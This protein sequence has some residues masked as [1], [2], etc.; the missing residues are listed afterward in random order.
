MFKQA[1]KN[2]IDTLGVKTL[3]GSRVKSVLDY[4]ID[5]TK[6]SAEAIKYLHTNTEDA[7]NII[8][9]LYLQPVYSTEFIEC[10]DPS[11]KAFL[12]KI[13]VN[14]DIQKASIIKSITLKIG[15][16]AD[17]HD[18]TYIWITDSTQNNIIAKSINAI[19]Q[20][21][22]VNQYVTWYFDYPIIPSGQIDILF[23]NKNGD[24]VYCRTHTVSGKTEGFIPV[25]GFSDTAH[26][27][28]CPSI[29]INAEHLIP[30]NHD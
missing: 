28:W 3:L 19:I 6:D 26:S 16:G 30:A 4:I 18:P 29:G 17:N 23:K 9:K 22:N 25:D 15:V 7:V 20:T 21:D 12:S 5:N 10:T 13:Y 11:H 8:N 27:E 1:C 2:L 24:L 14:E